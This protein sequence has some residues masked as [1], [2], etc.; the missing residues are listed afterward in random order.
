MTAAIT[1]GVSACLL[2]EHVRY[3]GGHKHDRYITDALGKYFNFIPVCP[4]VGCGLPIPRE[5]MRLEGDPAAPRLIT[6]QTRIDRT[7][8]MAAYCSTKIRELENSD[9]CGFIFK[10]DSPSSGLYRVKV[11][12]NGQAVK[13][14][15]GLFAA[16]VARHFPQLP[17]EEEGRL[18][19]PDIRENFIERV[20]SYRRW[21]DFQAANPA[22]G[23]LVE[24]HTAHKLLLMAH[25]PQVYRE[26]GRL[27]AHASELKLADVLRLYEELFMKGLALHAT[28]K[29][30]TNVLQHIM[31]YFKQQLSPDEK[32]ELLE[33]IRQYHDRLLPLIVPMT[34]LRHYISKYDQQYLKGQ[35]YLAPHPYQLMLRNHV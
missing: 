20:F 32:G 5:A 33:V 3:D 28:V 13:S 14:G 7:A 12:N 29:K 21:K 2:G 9:L 26:M 24:F 11:Y 25:S 30:N 8:Q 22:I 27:V 19:D 16:A 35:V 23:R 31:G 18:N 34:L 1:I 15:S 6:R 17:M 10:K 4:E